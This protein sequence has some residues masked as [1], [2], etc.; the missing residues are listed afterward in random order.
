MS[1]L[2]DVAVLGATGAVGQMMLEILQE[3]KF[4]IGT[5][6]PLASS[7]SAGGT[8]TFNGKQVEVLRCRDIRL[9]TST[10]RSVFSR[11]FS[12]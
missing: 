11:R 6:Y 9:D 4:P 2:Y 3:R 10:N 1:Q 7:R 5:I 12:V 8:V